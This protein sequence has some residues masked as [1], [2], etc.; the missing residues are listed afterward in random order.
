MAYHGLAVET[1]EKEQFIKNVFRKREF[2]SDYNA[3]ET[4]S[5]KRVIY[6]PQDLS[7]TNLINKQKKVILYGTSIFKGFP[8]A[9]DIDCMQIIPI[10]DQAKALRT[11]IMKLRLNQTDNNIRYFIGDIKCGIVSKFKGLS[12]YIGDYKNN[13]IVGYNYDACKYAF[14]LSTDLKDNKLILPK[15]ITNRKEFIEYLKCYDLAHELITRRWTVEDIKDGYQTN[16]DGTEY[17][18]NEAVYDSQLT[19]LD[20][21]FC[22]DLKIMEC[23]NTFMKDEKVNVDSFNDSLKLNMLIQYFVKDKKLKAIKRLLAL[24]RINKDWD[25]CLLLHDFTQR[26]IVGKYNGI[27]NNLKVLLFIIENY[28]LSFHNNPNDE[29]K[30]YIETFIAFIQTSIQKLYQPYKKVY[31]NIIDSFDDKLLDFIYYNDYSSESIFKML[32]F[33]K[34]TINYFEIEINHLSDKF[35][36]ENGIDIIFEKN[37]LF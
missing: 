36:K 37:L 26:S 16:E 30:G 23:T 8:L 19:K 2:P 32:N 25:M 18:L 20:L 12:Q 35:I 14:N 34:G 27:V 3:D 24:V 22:G 4:S 9:G 6:N 11:V 28:G 21:Y 5:I 10:K 13:K 29:R 15:K 7:D 31:R 33:I 1:K 17:S